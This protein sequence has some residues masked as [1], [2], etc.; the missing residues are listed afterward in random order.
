MKVDLKKGFE[1]KLTSPVLANTILEIL[2]NWRANRAINLPNYYR[3]PL[4]HDAIEEQ[5]Q[6]DWNNFAIG[7]C[8]RNWEERQQLHYYS[9]NSRR[10]FLRWAISIIKKFP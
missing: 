2:Q 7:R 5:Q 9:I 6:I 1:T 10:T 3:T 8:S 4:I